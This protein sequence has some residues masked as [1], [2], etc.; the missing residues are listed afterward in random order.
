MVEV[1]NALLQ[2]LQQLVLQSRC[3]MCERF[4]LGLLC[5][6]CR[7]QLETC[8]SAVP[9]TRVDNRP[10]FA[11]GCYQGPLKQLLGRL[12]Y[13]QQAQIA[14]L[15]GQL[16]GMAWLETQAHQRPSN[17]IPIPLHEIRQQERGY[18]QSALIAK[19]FCQ[20]TG[21]NLTLNGLV[22]VRAT[23]AQFKLSPQDRLINVAQA[24]QLGGGLTKSQCGKSIVLLDDIYTTGAT[25]HSAIEALSQAGFKVSGIAV[26]AKA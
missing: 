7:H 26:V 24:F 20:V 4:S 23:A 11:W 16:L 1:K 15:L 22:R 3:T 12:K 13:D 17:V 14:H 6:D 9:L 2:S 18:N 10:L 19:S 21:L 8:Q 5:P 25:V